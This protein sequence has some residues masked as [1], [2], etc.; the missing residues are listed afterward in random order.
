MSED[1]A[2][3]FRYKAFLSYSHAADGRLAPALQS[4]LHRF[5]KPWYRLRALRVFRDKTGL[6]VTH[7]LWPSI[8]EALLQ[9]EYFILLAS[10]EAAQSEWVQREVA[11]WL[12]ERKAPAQLLI[13]LTHGEVRW[14][15]PSAGVDWSQTDALPRRLSEAL[16]NEPKYLDMRWASTIDDLSPRKPEFQEAVAEL[17]ATLHHR[18]LDELIGDDVRQHRRV[19]IVT[20]AVVLV[21]FALSAFLA[22][23][24]YEAVQQRNE[25]QRQ[26]DKADHQRNVA[27]QRLT[28]I[29][30]ANGKRSEDD[31]DVSAALLWF[32]R[33]AKLDEGR[34]ADDGLLMRIASLLRRHPKLERMWFI[35]GPIAAADFDGGGAFVI[36][37][38]EDGAAHVWDA[39]SG[40]PAIKSP[41]QGADR[42]TAVSATPSGKR[43]ITVSGSSADV[44]DGASGERLVSLLHEAPINAAAFSPDGER[45]V[46]A[47][48]DNTARIWDAKSGRQVATLT[49]DAAVVDA[50]FSPDARAVLTLSGDATLRVWIGNTAV[51]LGNTKKL[52]RRPEMSPDARYVL[53]V[54]EDS[55]ARLWSSQTGAE[56]SSLGNWQWVDHA[57]FSPDGTHVV[58]ASR[59]GWASVR[60][61]TRDQEACDP[62]VTV[63]HQ[64]AVLDA[65]F[66][67]DG[68]WLATTSTD[69]TAR[70]WDARTG[71]P[72]GPPLWHGD[73]VDH[74]AFSPDGKQ[75]VTTAANGVV[76]VWNMRAGNVVSLPH[77]DAVRF[78]AFSPDGK[79][80][81]TATDF[82]AALWTVDGDAPSKTASLT[83]GAQVFHVCFSP[84]GKYV[85]TAS[86]DT[87][88]R[89]WD[90]E[91][92]KEAA[93][94]DHERRVA[95][96]AFSPDGKWLATAAFEKISVWNV[97]SGE[98]VATFQHSAPV[99]YLEFD[100]EGRR[101]MARDFGGDVRVWDRETAQELTA[102][103]RSSTYLV[104]L[105]P[106]GQR[107]ATVSDENNLEIGDIAGGHPVVLPI[108]PEYHLVEIAFSP[109]GTRLLTAGEGND[110]RVWDATTGAPVTSPLSHSGR[111]MHA[112]FSADGTQVLTA[113]TDSTAR[114]WNATTGDPITSPLE[115][116]GVVRYAAFSPDGRHLVTASEDHQ[117]RIWDLALDVP[118]QTLPSLT[119]LLAARR[120]DDTQA[121]RS[122]DAQE[123]RALWERERP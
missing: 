30:A 21:L 102:A 15:A 19:K 16:A 34:R 23:S 95:Y 78:A 60:D 94:L 9:S 107:L 116:G 113:S 40:E 63:R 42:V 33:A 17:A 88:A 93:T 1:H 36:A 22:I 26:R 28:K 77:E 71:K 97:S 64:G 8:K 92:G 39:G 65:A 100:A 3:G 76:R 53:T 44:R 90:T 123:L 50:L 106:D 57:R 48:D 98:R 109:D 10:P 7:E 20:W 67:P 86:A 62:E 82:A 99:T 51:T 5:A 79:R 81:L 118:V 112:V 29:N 12:D 41:P 73:T 25:A 35:G 13:V 52:A 84:D 115:H 38:S 49:H 45:I 111:V 31:G 14:A 11:C 114:V 120:I 58:M 101:I 104:R 69:Q 91:T 66:S 70:L 54:D 56:A 108:H 119:Q 32:A 105:S 75:L 85:L 122:L 83:S 68:Q 43:L 74:V 80:I 103:R 87:K 61:L 27:E 47:S 55:T 89:L 117:A 96:G 46:T 59:N 121:L 110:T 4:A 2:N 18:P 37:F 6:G 24:G 72:A